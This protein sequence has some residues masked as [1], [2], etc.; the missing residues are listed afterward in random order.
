LGEV[1][2]LGLKGADLRLREEFRE[3]CAAEAVEGVVGGGEE[4]VLDAEGRGV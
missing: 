2:Y 4:C 1:V 3:G